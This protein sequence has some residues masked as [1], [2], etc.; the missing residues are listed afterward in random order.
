AHRRRRRL[1]AFAARPGASPERVCGPLGLGRGRRHARGVRRGRRRG[2][3][4]VGLGHHDVHGARQAALPDPP[5]APRRARAGAVEE[6][7][8]DLPTRRISGRLMRIDANAFLGA[9]PYA[10]VPGTSPDGVLTAMQRTAIDEAWVTHL[11][12][13]FWRDP[14]EGNAWLYETCA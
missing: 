11:P 9:Y 6:R 8:A 2:A 1:A 14:T 10:R 12:S 7:G 13:L 5:A 4:A 3:A